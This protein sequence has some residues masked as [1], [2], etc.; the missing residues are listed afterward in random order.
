MKSVDLD[1]WIPNQVENMVL[2][3]N[4]KANQYWEHGLKDK[5]PSESNIDMWIR[6]KYEH[7]RWAMK[8][9]IPDPRTLTDSSGSQDE[10]SE[11]SPSF[12]Q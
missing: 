11:R 4:E 6:A 9:P 3:G 8:G 12:M 5:R 10:V 7:K 1:T 2:W